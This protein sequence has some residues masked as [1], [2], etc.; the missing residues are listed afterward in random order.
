M[1]RAKRRNSKKNKNIKIP[2]DDDDDACKKNPRMS[3]PNVPSQEVLQEKA[4]KKPCKTRKK[5]EWMEMNRVRRQEG[6]SKTEGV[7]KASPGS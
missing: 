6:W 1:C 5:Q 4:K 2:N 7:K 3:L